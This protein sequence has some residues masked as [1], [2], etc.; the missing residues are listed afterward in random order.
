MPA[1]PHLILPRVEYELVRRK[2]GFGLNPAREYRTHGRRLRNQLDTVLHRFRTVRLPR[3]I[4]P[5]LIL[6]VQL[7]HEA[8]LDEEMWERCGLTLLSIDENKTL[9]LFSSDEELAGFNRR[10]E[11]Y[12]AGPTREKQKSSPHSGLFSCI[13]EIGV[14]QPEDRIGRL[15]RM[16]GITTPENFQANESYTVDVELWDLGVR[17]LCR[18]RLNEIRT[19]IESCNGRVTDD[20]FGESMVLFRTQ[21]RGEVVRALL[22]I[23]SVALVDLPPQPSLTI[24][25]YL[26]L[27]IHD[28]PD[29]DPPDET[30]PSVTVLD[31]GLVSAHPLVAPAV[32]EATT[33][34]ARWGDGTDEHG[35]GTMVCG[36]AL[37]GDVEKC[38]E[39]R[40]FVPQLTLY[41]GRVVNAQCEFDDE[42]L[43]T[44][45]MRDAIEYFRNTY[46]C[47]AF[48]L[49]LGDGRLT[50]NGGKV[51]PWASVL[52]TLTRELDVVIVVSAGNYIHQPDANGTPDEHVQDYP[53]YLLR[54]E[55][56]IIEPATGAIVLTVGSLSDKADVPP[57]FAE[58]SVAFRPI[59][60]PGQPSPFT[61]TGLGLGGAIKPELCSP[62][63]NTAY[64][65][66]LRDVRNNVRELSVVSLNREY[67]NRLF[68]T[69]TGTSF[70]TPKITHMA[71]RLFGTFPDA[72]AN[73]IRAFLV[74][75]AKVPEPSLNLL[76]PL[77]TGTVYRVCGYGCPDLETAWAS[78]ENRVVLFSEAELGLDNFHI[79]EVPIPEELIVTN[80][81]RRIS[82]TLS[83]DPP[84]RHSRFDYLGT[85]MSFR[86]IRGRSLEE[87]VRAFTPRAKDETVEPLRSDNCRMHPG[88]RSREG[89]TL[90]RAVFTMRR[91]PQRDYGDTYYLVVRCEKKWAREE[92]EPQRYAVVVVLEHSVDVNLYARARL[93]VEAAVRIRAQQRAT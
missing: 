52:D 49:S 78:D 28:F 66:L 39:E 1:L 25:E 36:L 23:Q 46:D 38:I 47:R 45:Q 44:S 34:P 4:N 12:Q 67:L 42:S 68:E 20:Y 31:S 5:D 29:I 84:V 43:I 19:Y 69:A 37:Y 92:H 90:Q 53:R 80:G 62:G 73:L 2:T 14:V 55:A 9:I 82:V 54:N 15:V 3:G 35:H 77:G 40:S 27:G 51:S 22:E 57:G 87:V 41:S 30:A 16:A 83:F 48:N 74:A 18:Q 50:Y 64:D 61:R 88:P 65:G 32:G 24:G 76:E 56:R 58:N 10:L 81:T 89:G 79:Y 11:E 75:S 13:D 59:A 60:L 26:D 17:Q 93:R 6:R 71:A 85:K 21:C 63:G 91:A 72:S 8:G 33:I 86:L 70:A 7:N